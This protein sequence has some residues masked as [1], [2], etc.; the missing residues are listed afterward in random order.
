MKNPLLAALITSWAAL[1]HAQ[2]G[3]IFEISIARP[4]AAAPKQGYSD[5][6]KLMRDAKQ[7]GNSA[8]SA[9]FTLNGWFE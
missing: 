4:S 7:V 6:M 2:S 5:P 9:R 1:S 3:R 8:E